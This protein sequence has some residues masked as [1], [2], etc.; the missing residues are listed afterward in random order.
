MLLEQAQSEQK[1]L[2]GLIR[3]SRNFFQKYWWHI[4]LGIAILALILPP[5]IK[6]IKRSR[7][8]KKLD[9]LRT[10]LVVIERLLKKAQEECFKSKKITVETY[11]I[12]T[13]RYKSKMAEI[14]HTIPVLEA[15]ASGKKKPEE[16]QKREGMLKI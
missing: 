6:R 9:S 13:E 2:K 8:K 3:L 15:I 1:R 5:M 12:R 4:L 14:K 16:K 7:A 11:K 10:E